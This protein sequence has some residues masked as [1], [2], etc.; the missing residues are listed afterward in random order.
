MTTALALALALGGGSAAWA[1]PGGGNG[2]ASAAARTPLPDGWALKRTTSGADLTWQAPE[3]VPTGDAMVEFYAGDRLLGRPRA[4]TDQRTFH[5]VIDGTA[6]R[7]LTDLQVRAG[8]RRLD[9]TAKRPGPTVDRAEPLA[10]TA[11]RLSAA[12]PLPANPVDPGVAGPYSTVSGD[13]SLADVQLPGLAQPVEMKAVVVA[14]QGTAGPRPLVL[15]MHGR[16]DTCYQGSRGLMVAWPC[17]T[18]WTALESH[19]GYLQT[20]QLLASQGYVTVSISANGITAQDNGDDGQALPPEDGGAQARSSLV[21]LHLGHWA[22]WAG[23]GRAGAPD[24]VQSA[25]VA[26]MSRV[27]LVGHSRGGE[28]VSRAAIDSLTPPSADQDG[29]RGAVRWHIRGLALIGPTIFGGQNPAPDLP[30][31]VILPSCDGDMSDLQGQMYVD[32]TRGVSRGFALHS[33]VYVLGANHN[34]FNTQWSPGQSPA[35]TWEDYPSLHD[36]SCRADSPLRLAPEVQQ[37]VGATYIAAAAATF[38]AGN[39]QVRP[40]L[41]GSGVRAPSADPATVLTHAVGGNRTP[42]LVPDASTVV[43]GAES[44]LCEAVT[45]DYTR[46]CGQSP[47]FAPLT[48]VVPEAERYAVALSW[49]AAGIPVR[50]RRATPTSVSGAQSVALRISVPANSVVPMD[51]A[52]VDSARRR[53]TLGRVTITGTPRPSHTVSEWAQEVRVPLANATAAGLDL[54]R[55]AELV[56]VPHST[57]GRASL[58]DAW[59]WSP[60][61]PAPQPIALPRVDVGELTVLEG[62][63]GTTTYQVPTRVSGSG[64]GQVR[65]FVVD[66]ATSLAT[67]QVVIVSPGMTTI[68]IPVS[69]TGNTQAGDG[70]TYIV[71]VKAIKGVQVGDSYGSLTVQDD[72]S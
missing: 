2:S 11:Q 8:G 9:A 45:N 37:R 22:D 68:S 56:L 15:L 62:D 1:E 23:T 60:G 49:S 13:Y 42:L 63:A 70:R 59:G 43:T 10:A 64:T 19:R 52:I 65:V 46:S 7:D 41:D 14:P 40:L 44:R 33:A 12:E 53:A 58:I 24:I 71:A 67:A 4:G 55:I 17:P 30:S 26:D 6:A 61:T 54:T 48:P 5:L 29:Y 16:H 51:V 39:D 25:P 34:Y 35:H 47:H 36:P 18:G 72:D 3:R 69:V 21:R 57:V 27:L 31:M 38:V 66:P 28:G 32:A 50:V 20:Q